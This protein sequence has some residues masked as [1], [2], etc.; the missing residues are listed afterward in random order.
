MAE[1]SSGRR[2]VLESTA[3]VGS[4]DVFQ[5][6]GGGVTA[7]PDSCQAERCGV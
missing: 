1:V 5:E 6:G 3:V 2:V 7:C 4:A